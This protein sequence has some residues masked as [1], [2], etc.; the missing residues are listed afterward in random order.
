MD[1]KVY[2]FLRSVQFC[3]SLLEES[4]RNFVVLRLRVRDALSWLV[5]PKR[6]GFSYNRYIGRRIDL[7]KHH[8][9]LVK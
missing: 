3:Q 4:V 5:V 7:F 1:F 8:F 2:F 9:Y 6:P